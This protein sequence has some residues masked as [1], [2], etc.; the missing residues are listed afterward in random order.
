[1]AKKSSNT[2]IDEAISSSSSNLSSNSEIQ[3]TNQKSTSRTADG[4]EGAAV[5][6]L[7]RGLSIIE[8]FDVDH[9]EWYLV[10][11]CAQTGLH[12]STAFRLAKTL[13]AKGFLELDPKSGAYRLGTKLHRTAYL[14]LSNLELANI[15]HAHMEQLAEVI[16]ETI[17]LSVPIAE[18]NLFV[19]QVQTPRPFKPVSRVGIVFTG[20][21][22]SHGK[23][24][25]AFA[26]EYQKD[27]LLARA[28][29][30]V[31]PE[32][33]TRLEADLTQAVQSGI[34]YDLEEST[35]GIHALAVPVRDFSGN[36]RAVLGIVAPQERLDDDRMKECAEELLKTAGAIA[37]DLG[38][39]AS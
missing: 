15:A 14:A 29:S 21:F 24:T 35:P 34:A 36:L 5:R 16:G 17:D 39:C 2:E 6:S 22:N 38:S 26:P 32:K 25:L 8:C 11:I 9:P 4:D 10:D 13:T 37:R 1:V 7:A 3:K 23:I 20:Y 27:S 28:K 33:W 12:I 30:A 31:T 18:G 19:A